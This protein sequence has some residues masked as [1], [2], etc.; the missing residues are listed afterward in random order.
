MPTPLGNGMQMIAYVY[1]NHAGDSM[2][3][4]SRTGFLVFLQ[5]APIYWK[6]KKQGTIE[7]NSSGSKFCAIKT[8]CEYVIGIQYKLRM[9]GIDILGE[10]TYIYRDNQSVLC[11]TTVPDSLLKK[12]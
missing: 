10:P 5:C 2:T 12:K 6:S 11:N 9:M 4:R 3:R 8:A 1:S 7:T